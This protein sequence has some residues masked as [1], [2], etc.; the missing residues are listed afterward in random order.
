VLAGDRT[1]GQSTCLD[2]AA[3]DE[4]QVGAVRQYQA[5]HHT[6]ASGVDEPAG[7]ADVAS[8]SVVDVADD[9]EIRVSGVHVL[10]VLEVL[11]SPLIAVLMLPQALRNQREIP[12]LVPQL[13]KTNKKRKE[14]CRAVIP[15]SDRAI[16]SQR[17]NEGAGSC[18]SEALADETHVGDVGAVVQVQGDLV[19]DL[20]GDVR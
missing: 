16:P 18:S 2:L 1:V 13:R 9:S 10:P 7:L 15:R 14:T 12:N 17:A 3:G 20:V 8:M 5:K 11:P 19:E 6:I 4:A